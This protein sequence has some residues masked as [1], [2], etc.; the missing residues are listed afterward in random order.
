VL[1]LFLQAPARLKQPIG[2]VLGDRAGLALGFQR[3]TLLAH[4]RPTAVW[5]NDELAGIELDAHRP[6]LIRRRPVSVVA[7]ALEALLD[8]AQ[9]L[10][11]PFAGPQLLGQ[12]VAALGPVELVLAAVD[13]G[14]LGENLARDLSKVTIRVARR[15][16]RHLGPVDRH[17]PNRHEPDPREQPRTPEHTSPSGR[18]CRQRNSAIV[19]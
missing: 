10:A 19:E 9:R 8:L 4:P 7:L 2:A 1:E 5:P 18:S 12:L 3:A 6:P 14:R 17:H 11:P 15:V 13:L 16:G